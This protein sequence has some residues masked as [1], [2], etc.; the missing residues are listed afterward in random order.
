ML[1]EHFGDD[2][3]LALLSRN[4]IERAQGNPFFLEELVNAIAER[5]DFEGE[6]GAYRLKGG[7]D[8]IPLPATVQAVVAARIDHLEDVAKQVLETA[9]VIGRVVSLS[10]LQRVTALPHDE[11][12]EAD[13]ASPAGRTAVRSA[14]LR[15]GTSCVSPSPDPGGRLPVAVA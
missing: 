12:S 10:I 14:A 2:P 15:P 11:L 7:I 5:G 8:A 9:S 13:L 4:I 3:S 6:R 1:Q